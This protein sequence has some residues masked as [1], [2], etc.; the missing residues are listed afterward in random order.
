MPLT[1]TIR[2]VGQLANGSALSLVLDR[3]G[4]IIG[5]AATSDWCLP[6]PTLHVSSRHCEV[7][8]SGDVYELVDHSTNGTFLYGQANRLSAP[9][10]VRSGD[11]FVVGQYEVAAALDE[12]SATAAAQR[13][14]AP[15]EPQ[16][17]GWGAAGNAHDAAPSTSASAWGRP[18]DQAAISGGGPMS[19]SW[20]APA[21]TPVS[22]PAASPWNQVATPP[23]PSQ[24]A[25][26]WSSPQSAPPPP[27]GDD[28][29]GKFA[30]SNVVDWARGG[31]G[32]SNS[33]PPV[34][35]FGSVPSSGFPAAAAPPIPAPSFAFAAPDPAPALAP[36]Q[37]PAFAEQTAPPMAQPATVASAPSPAPAAGTGQSAALLA[38]AGIEPDRIT[39]GDAELGAQ[40][41]AMLRQLVAGLVVMLEA[42]ARAKSQ[43]GAS[44]TNLEFDG[45]NPLK[46][47][48]T[49]D[50]ALVQM[51]NP[52]QRGFMTTERAIE[53]AFRDLQAHQV[54]TLRA[55]QGALRATLDRFSP[56]AIR[57]RAE[58]G[59]F[60]RK[61]MPGA[62][63]AALWAA[64][65]KE[66][67]G[68]AIGSDEAF[69]D[70]FAKEFRIAYEEATARR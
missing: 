37:T 23:P 16:W 55:M 11:V 38:A 31:F 24:P 20:A 14:A 7:R 46:F 4:A 30:Q 48:R 17:Q 18:P 50:Q 41:G 2:N 67:Q 27:T 19:Q 29:W 59:G 44:G 43:L 57:A 39:V 36:S 54:A 22:E 42:R 26:D 3:R 53:D 56:S 68:V 70:M 25:S 63:D 33:P 15:V 10:V 49:P 1:L 47:A 35:S 13:N 34:A 6:D 21:V 66:F 12:A 9:H 60:L 51:L 64:Y 40:V 32:Q 8:F 58:S 69:M 62:R 45:N 52:A 28:L 61:I 65:E 5:R